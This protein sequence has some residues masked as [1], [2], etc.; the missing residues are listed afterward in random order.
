M[1]GRLNDREKCRKTRNKKFLQR[2]EENNRRRKGRN[3]V[4]KENE[5]ERKKERYGRKTNRILLRLN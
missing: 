4:Q 2:K 1:R 3:H 5:K